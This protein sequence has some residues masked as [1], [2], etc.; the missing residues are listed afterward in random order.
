[1]TTMLV[2]R[3]VTEQGDTPALSKVLQ[4]AKRKFL[5]VILDGLAPRVDGAVQ[6]KLAAIITNEA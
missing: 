4:E 1:M 6:E 5:A 3:T 2:L